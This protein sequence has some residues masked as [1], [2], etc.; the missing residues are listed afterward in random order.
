MDKT[1]TIKFEI[2]FINKD[3]TREGIT[4]NDAD[5][6]KAA[7]SFTF[8]PNE[9][10]PDKA[11]A[12]AMDDKNKDMVPVLV[13][14]LPVAVPIGFGKPASSNLASKEIQTMLKPLL[15]DSKPGLTVSS[16][17]SPTMTQS[18]PPSPW[19]HPSTVC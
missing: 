2:L 12:L 3:L 9:F 17:L 7:L 11:A 6:S 15:T 16:T 13:I 8:L 4:T 19:T 18:P 10:P 14:L 5:A 1:V